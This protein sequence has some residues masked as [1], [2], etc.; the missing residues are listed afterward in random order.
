MLVLLNNSLFLL[1]YLFYFW[2]YTMTKHRLAILI[3]GSG[4]N[5]LN[6][7]GY[8]KGVKGVEIALLVSNN[9]DSLALQKA[10][11]EGVE[12]RVFNN[13]TFKKNG[14]IL[15]ILQ[16]YSINFIVLAGFLL[17]IP[18]D[19]VRAFPKKIVNI[20]PSLL[21]KFG[22]KG[23]YGLHVHQ[24]VIEEREKESG[25][26]IHYVNEEYDEGAI[27]FQ[28]KVS[29]DSEDSSLSLAKK[30]QLLEHKHLPKVIERILNNEEY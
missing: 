6:I 14:E 5:A 13:Q 4:T 26:S 1:K 22:G 21:P 12:T 24:A 2:A 16:S 19:V 23:M 17:K 10:K 27:I 9:A 3:S 18:Q 28:A 30:I 29:V 11:K 20:H 15:T 25:I 8:F 7:I